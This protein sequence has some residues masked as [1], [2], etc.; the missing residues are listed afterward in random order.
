M[1]WVRGVVIDDGDVDKDVIDN[2]GLW[3]PVAEATAGLV[4]SRRNGSTVG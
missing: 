3:V 2:A 1:M 4:S